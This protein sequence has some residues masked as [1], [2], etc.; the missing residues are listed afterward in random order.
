[1]QTIYHDVELH[2]VMAAQAA[3]DTGT[4]NSDAIATGDCDGVAFLVTLGAMV[5][6][7]NVSAKLT[8]RLVAGTGSWV[9]VPDAAAAFESDGTDDVE[10]LIELRRPN[11]WA[12][13]RCEITRADQNATIDAVTAL[14]YKPASRPVSQPAEMAAKAYV[15]GG[16][17]A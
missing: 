1:M 6:G 4:V 7:S 13:V 9:D 10:M 16:A 8:G 12:E 2:H 11:P 14:K 3:S 17:P 5:S 15:L